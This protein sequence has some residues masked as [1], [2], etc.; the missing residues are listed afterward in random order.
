MLGPSFP[1]ATPRPHDRAPKHSCVY[2]L[3]TCPISRRNNMS[4]H[5][6]LMCCRGLSQQQN[7]GCDLPKLPS[8]LGTV[9]ASSSA[10]SVHPSTCTR[11]CSCCWPGW[12]VPRLASLLFAGSGGGRR[13]RR[14]SAFR[15]GRGGADRRSMVPHHAEAYLSRSTWSSGKGGRRVSGDDWGVR[16]RVLGLMSTKC[17][18]AS[19]SESTICRLLLLLAILPKRMR[20][21][22]TSGQTHTFFS[23]VGGP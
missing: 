8:V 18:G 20:W 21:G 1:L 10:R 2:T 15:Q 16:W 9:H 7:K 12:S 4:S 5:Q 23:A 3:D 22:T 11:Y 19:K 6:E 17:L 14:L 13:Q